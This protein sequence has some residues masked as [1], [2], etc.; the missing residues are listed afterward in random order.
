[1]DFIEFMQTEREDYLRN[2]RLYF[3]STLPFYD[4]KLYSTVFRIRV[5]RVRIGNACAHLYAFRLM[6][7]VCC[8]KKLF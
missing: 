4:I 7:Y 8:G 5:F 6:F 2:S 1:M 3:S